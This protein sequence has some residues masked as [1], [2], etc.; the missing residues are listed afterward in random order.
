MTQVFIVRSA[1]RPIYAREAEI[2]RGKFAWAVTK[3]GR[4]HLIG[5][6]AFFTKSAAVRCKF[7][8]LMEFTKNTYLHFRFPTTL[9]MARRQLEEYK[10]K[11]ADAWP[12]RLK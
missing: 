4:R 8:L 2:Q 5:S 6:T 12:V 10:L 1:C 3:E 7:A 9:D 11:G